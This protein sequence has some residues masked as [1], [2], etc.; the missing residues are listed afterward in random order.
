MDRLAVDNR[1]TI[2]PPRSVTALTRPEQ[3][4]WE[5]VQNGRRRGK[6]YH[7]RERRL[8]LP[9]H[10]VSQLVRQSH[11]AQVE[12]PSASGRSSAG[13]RWWP[14]APP[15]TRRARALAPCSR[16]PALRQLF[17]EEARFD[18]D[19]FVGILFPILVVPGFL[20][21]IIHHGDT[22]VTW[23][24]KLTTSGILI[25]AHPELSRRTRPPR[26]CGVISESS[27]TGHPE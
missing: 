23:F 24:D 20:W 9:H 6:N 1:S 7:R 10:T 15:V 16:G 3:S 4:P 14:I 18:R 25:S 17:F 26:L 12:A 13:C 22:E 27:F 11:R 21:R 2:T 19:F 8:H 5:S